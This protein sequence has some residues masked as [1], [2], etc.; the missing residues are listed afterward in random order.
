MKTA[1]L[2][3][4]LVPPE[5]A[6]KQSGEEKVWRRASWLNDKLFFDRPIDDQAVEAM[7]HLSTTR[8]MEL[9]K[10]V[11]EKAVGK[12]QLPYRYSRSMSF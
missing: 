6:A 7:C 12:A 1:A 2:R 3:D 9:F 8:A 10:D 5:Q 11:E 4:G